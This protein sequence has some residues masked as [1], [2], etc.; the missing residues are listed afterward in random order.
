MKFLTIE[1]EN[2]GIDDLKKHFGD[3]SKTSFVFIHMNGCGHCKDM[4]SN[5]ANLNDIFKD[6]DDNLIIAKINSGLQDTFG[7]LLSGINGYPSINYI[8]N[9]KIVESYDGNRSAESLAKWINSHYKKQ[10][11]GGRKRTKKNKTKT[12]KKR[13]RKNKKSK[14]RR[15]Y[16]RY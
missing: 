2:D 3:D 11:G 7:D 5:W 1:N 10:L 12:K 15:R 13:T 6:R 16:K 8:K 9:N 14:K 4:M